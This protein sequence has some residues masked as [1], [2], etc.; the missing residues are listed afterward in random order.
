PFVKT[1]D[2]RTAGLSVSGT[3][4]SG[5]AY[6]GIY[7]GFRFEAVTGESVRT[8]LIDTALKLLVPSLGKLPKPLES[9]G[10]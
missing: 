2:G 3:S 10:E 7:L 1:E 6:R 5:N 9:N 4:E 8:K